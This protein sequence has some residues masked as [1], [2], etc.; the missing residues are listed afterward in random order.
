VMVVGLLLCSALLIRAMS[1]RRPFAAPAIDLTF[2]MNGG[3]YH[4]VSAGSAGL[5]NAHLA[6][7]SEPRFRPWRGQSYGI[8]LVRLNRWGFRARGAMPRSPA[9]YVIYGDSVHAPCDGTVVEASDGLADLRPPSPDRE[10]MAG[11][12]VLLDCGGT[13]V[14]L[15]HLRQRSV[16]IRRGDSVRT[17]AF[18]GSVGNTGNS[19]EPHLHIHAQRPGSAAAPLSG[20]PVP[21]TFGGRHL[22]RNARLRTPLSGEHGAFRDSSAILYTRG[23]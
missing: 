4:A 5:L 11:N 8:D 16:R 1:G 3:T 10:H 23:R 22:V 19:S 15:G 17:G 2:P 12:H 7:L 13:W 20:D 18:L 9:A 21:I 14:L 6:T